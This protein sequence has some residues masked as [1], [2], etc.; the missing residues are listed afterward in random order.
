MA[1]KLKVVFDEMVA[2]EMQRRRAIRA[3]LQPSPRERHCL[4]TLA[5]TEPPK[6]LKRRID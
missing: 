1:I 2:F 5:M 4:R 6:P 3:W